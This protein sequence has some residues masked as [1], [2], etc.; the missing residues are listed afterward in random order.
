MHYYFDDLFGNYIYDSVLNDTANISDAFFHAAKE[1]RIDLN[2]ETIRTEYE[3]L[4]QRGFFPE[5]KNFIKYPNFNH[6]NSLFERKLSKVTIQV[7]QA[8]NFRCKYC[9]YSGNDG[10]ERVHSSKFMKWETMKKAL[11]FVHEKSIDSGMIT[12]GF[13]GGEPLL[14]F[15]LIQD[16]IEYCEKIFEGKPI[17]FAMTTN[18]TL[19]SPEILSFLEKRNV[20]LTISLDGPKALN[21]KNRIFASSTDSTFEAV[22]QKIK[23]IVHDYRGL[24]KY[25][26]INMVLDPSAP[27][28][29]FQKIFDEIPE[30]SE[31]IVKASVVSDDGLSVQHQYSQQFIEESEYA[32]FINRL[33]KRPDFVGSTKINDR[34][35]M[36]GTFDQ[37]MAQVRRMIGKSIHHFAPSGPCVPLY[38]KLFIDIDGRFLPCEKVSEV[39]SDLCF[40]DINS[41]VIMQK[42][43]NLVEIASITKE[44]CEN[45][46]CFNMCSSCVKY[47]I[48]TEGISRSNF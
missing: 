10:T 24:L 28:S 34:N 46:W 2:N 32:N 41:G 47:C 15:K 12:I 14:N 7:T 25:L 26:S 45:C 19:L 36:G 4:Q 44:E 23:M 42:L 37:G 11:D 1:N 16:A 35:I 13:Y 31:V 8:C 3:E 48:D 22:K 39:V 20:A 18:A 17:L 5:K 43:I 21:D 33:A 30:L 9:V 29:E 6:A 38:N 27:Y 40:G